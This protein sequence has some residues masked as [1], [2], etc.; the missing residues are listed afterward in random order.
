[1]TRVGIPALDQEAIFSTVAAVLHLGNI[2]FKTG[3]NEAAVPADALAQKH[4]Q[5]C[6]A[7]RRGAAWGVAHRQ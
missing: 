5:H 1:M 4:L 6:G 7:H 2:S 3:G